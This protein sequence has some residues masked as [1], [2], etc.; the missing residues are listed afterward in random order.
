M[1]Q[2]QF[3][4]VFSVFRLKKFFSAHNFLGNMTNACHNTKVFYFFIYYAHFYG[5]RKPEGGRV[6]LK[7]F[8]YLPATHL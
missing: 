7:T 1:K 8:G 3:Y 6:G 4:Y 2:K 5:E